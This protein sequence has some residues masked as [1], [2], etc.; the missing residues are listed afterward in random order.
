M[1]VVDVE[2]YCAARR[3]AEC[4]MRK[5]GEG[6]FYNV[7]DLGNG[8][9]LKKVK[10]GP[11]LFFGILKKNFGHWR[12]FREYKKAIR[13]LVNMD[14]LYKQMLQ[15]IKEPWMLG[16]PEFIDG[17]SYTQ[18]KV[19]VL[20]DVLHQN[21]SEVMFK[22]YVELYIDHIKLFWNYGC[23]ELV[24]NFTINT[25]VDSNGRLIAID[26][27]EVTFAKDNAIKSITDSEW[28]HRWSYYC[29]S[30]SE[31]KYYKQRMESE[32][33]VAALNRE[34]GMKL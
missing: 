14:E 8:R 16:N 2:R 34:W 17:I 5:I 19:T 23:H 11:A 4:V 27:N 24:Y 31:K 10:S 22:K 29:M 20:K 28:L 15:Q 1:E 21:S 25:G 3:R 13:Q 6:Y 12:I 33:T 7:Y 9:V 30:S 32:I 26:F 18:D